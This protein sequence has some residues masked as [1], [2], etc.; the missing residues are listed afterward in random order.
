MAEAFFETGIGPV[1]AICSVSA[2]CLSGDVVETFD[3]HEREQSVSDN[4]STHWTA[5]PLIDQTVR[6]LAA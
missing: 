4:A 6:Q 5:L 3:G 2:V 1:I